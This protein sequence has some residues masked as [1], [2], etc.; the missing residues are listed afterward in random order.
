MSLKM[1]NNIICAL[2]GI[3]KKNKCIKTREYQSH[4]NEKLRSGL[5]RFPLN[6]IKNYQ[7]ISSGYYHINH[8]SKQ[9][10]VAKNL[11]KFSGTYYKNIS[12]IS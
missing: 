12:I 4:F 10:F 1:K 6:I 7:A 9:V 2:E 5:V 3:S 11:S 8:G